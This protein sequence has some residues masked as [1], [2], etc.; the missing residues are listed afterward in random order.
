VSAQ[1]LGEGAAPRWWSEPCA[2]GCAGTIM[3]WGPR[4]GSVVVHA[5]CPLP[6]SPDSGKPDVHYV[7][8]SDT[9]R[10]TDGQT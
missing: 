6:D 7:K 1:E 2:G 8:D 4:P 10:G 9:C 5:G 3:V